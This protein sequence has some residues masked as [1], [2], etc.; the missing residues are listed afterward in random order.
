MKQPVK[1]N[2]NGALLLSLAAAFLL[3]LLLYVTL[4]SPLLPG[5]SGGG[6]TTST[7]TTGEGEGTGI[8]PGTLLLFPRIER[9][10]MRSLEVFNSYDA[11]RGD[12]ENR[13]TF[14][15]EIPP[16]TQIVEP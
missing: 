1:I 3:L 5:A 15:K 12:Y 16:Y 13:Y 10:R 2:R 11:A 7:V 14:L 9:A 8:T 4:L 6:T